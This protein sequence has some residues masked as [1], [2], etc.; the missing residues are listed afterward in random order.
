M[1]SA[2]VIAVTGS[3]GKTTTTALLTHIL[4][5]DGPVLSQIATN[6]YG[7]AL[8]TLNALRRDHRYVAIEQG[9]ERPG[10]LPKS[11]ALIS[12]D[13]AVVTLVAIEHYTAFRN[14]DAVA[15]E[16]SS[17]VAR[18]PHTGVAILN[19]DDPHVRAMSELTAARAVTF[20]TSGGDYRVENISICQNGVLSFTL[21][22]GDLTV[23][24]NTQLLGKYNWLSVAAAATCALELGIPPAMVKDRIA[25][26]TPVRGRMSLHTLA[27]GTR[28]ILDTAKAPY[29]SLH[30]PLETLNAMAAP[31]KRFVMGQISD[32]SGNATKK[33]KDT[34]AAASKVADEVCFVGPWGHKARAPA[35]DVESGKFRSFSSLRDLSIHLKETAVEGEVVVVK[36]ARNLHL[37][38]LL[39]DRIDE[40]HCWAVECGVKLSCAD[41]GLYRRA[42]HE[43]NG[44]NPDRR[45]IAAPRSVPVE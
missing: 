33:Y 12:P 44:R 16:K 20:G 1:T 8:K 35:A 18:L 37:D 3:S 39:L 29:H 11:A 34:Y 10:D 25:S 36:S 17:F 43:H 26:F 9:T 5:G 13:V 41:C 19:F 21:R 14:I 32:Y 28:M 42:Y 2:T 38:R 31:K 6:M 23:P 45:R 22:H 7:D 4:S 27:D 24:L 30:L 15:T 40:V